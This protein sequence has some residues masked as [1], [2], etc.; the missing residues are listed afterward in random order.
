MQKLAYLTKFSESV[1]MRGLALFV[2]RTAYANVVNDRS[3]PYHTAAMT[4]FDPYVDMSRLNLCYVP[5][6]APIIL[7]PTHPIIPLSTPKRSTNKSWIMGRFFLTLAIILLLPIWACFFVLANLYQQYY[8]AQRIREHFQHHHENHEALDYTTLNE[9]VQEAFEGV[10]DNAALFSTALEEPGENEYT[11]DYHVAEEMPL[12]NGNAATAAV[13]GQRMSG[14]KPVSVNKEEYKLHLSD[15]QVSMMI[16]LRSIAWRTFGVHINET[17]H[18]HAAIIRRSKWRRALV[19][20]N[21]VIQHWLDG[22][23]QA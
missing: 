22:Q 11:L 19:E 20:G 3:V 1:F 15:E 9:V 4:Q 14:G 17:R 2:N 12:L 10:V 23:F 6:Y 7:H 18:S 13:N 21:I 8:S 16:G 5:S